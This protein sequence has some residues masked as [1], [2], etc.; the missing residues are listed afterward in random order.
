MKK[1]KYFPGLPDFDTS[2]A[3]CSQ[4][5]PELFFP[6]HMTSTNTIAIAKSICRE[7]PVQVECLSFALRTKETEGIWGG[8]TPKERFELLRKTKGIELTTRGYIKYT[9]GRG[10]PR[11]NTNI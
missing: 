10:R 11:T 7:C 9:N 1:K 8:M 3:L 2:S 5:D 6:E 4:T